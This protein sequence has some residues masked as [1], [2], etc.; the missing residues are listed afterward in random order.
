MARFDFEPS[1]RQ[2]KDERSRLIGKAGDVVL[3]AGGSHLSRC[4]GPAAL[5][6][7]RKG[8]L[9]TRPTYGMIWLMA[10][11]CRKAGFPVRCPQCG[12]WSG[13]ANGQRQT[14][15]WGSVQQIRCWR[16]GCQHQWTA[17]SG[18]VAQ[19]FAGLRLHVRA[20]DLLKAIGL[21]VIGLPMRRV[22]CLLG[23]KGETVRAK[24]AWLL[25]HDRWET[26]K[27]VLGKRWR[28]PPSYFV[29]FEAVVT[30]H[31]GSGD[32]VFR[33]WGDE[34]EDRSSADR[35]GTMRLIARI[36][37]RPVSVIG[38]GSRRHGGRRRNP[39][40]AG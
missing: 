27:A 20:Q 2:P 7:A 28:I 34:L 22:E 6:G 3:W 14:L 37:G 26:L 40:R 8:C 1:H 39:R 38:W 35:A 21:L 36:A 25:D 15:A 31:W 17:R 23:I 19:L 10:F 33:Y 29:D 32:P 5:M 4:S 16:K 30:D 24:L 9:R 11:Q 12:R 13:R 18:E